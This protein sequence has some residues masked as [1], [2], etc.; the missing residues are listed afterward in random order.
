MGIVVEIVGIHSYVDIAG[1]LLSHLAL[2]TPNRQDLIAVYNDVVKNDGNGG[3]RWIVG[4]NP[5]MRIDYIDYK[6][7]DCMLL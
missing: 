5:A 3:R 4:K 2:S 7:V 6:V 1:V